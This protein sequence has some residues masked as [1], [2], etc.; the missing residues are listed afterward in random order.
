MFPRRAVPHRPLR[1][2]V[3]LNHTPIIISPAFVCT[4]NIFARIIDEFADSRFAF[5]E[6]VPLGQNSSVTIIRKS[7]SDRNFMP[8]VF[9]FFLKYGEIDYLLF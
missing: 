5:A 1:D 4:G 6:H 7:E 9:Q 8:D 2:A 3:S